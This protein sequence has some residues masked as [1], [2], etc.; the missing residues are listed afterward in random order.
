M[1][2]AEN[3]GLVG[4]SESQTVIHGAHTSRL[5]IQELWLHYHEGLAK[6]KCQRPDMINDCSGEL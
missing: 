3:K 6:T 2:E 5:P 1:G 4:P